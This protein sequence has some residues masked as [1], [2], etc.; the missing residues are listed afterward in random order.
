[1][2]CAN[3]QAELRHDLNQSKRDKMVDLALPA[4][5]DRQY[6]LMCV[7]L[8]QASDIGQEAIGG[9]SFDDGD[10]GVIAALLTSARNARTEEIANEHRATLGQYIINRI[11]DHML[12]SF[13][14]QAQNEV[15]EN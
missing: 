10:Y 2:S 1:M 9:E 6:W 8:A 14:E 11:E 13:E 12:P 3:S 5:E 7:S 4:I 15:L